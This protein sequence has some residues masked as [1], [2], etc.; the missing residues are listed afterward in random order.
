VPSLFHRKSSDPWCVA[1]IDLSSRRRYASTRT[2]DRPAAKRIGAKLEADAALRRNGVVNVRD[3][4]LAAQNRVP[5]REH[6]ADYVRPLELLGR[7]E[8]HVRATR[9]FLESLDECLGTTR[10]SVI[11]Q[12]AVEKYLHGLKA[13]GKSARTLNWRQS[14]VAGF[15]AW[16]VRAGRLDASPQ[17][18]LHR[19]LMR[20]ASRL[21]S[22]TPFH[23]PDVV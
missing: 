3:E 2:T 1:W 23:A 5:L 11:T 16:A 10:L 21:C 19:G 12:D 4:Q 22:V 7:T 20:E 17:R 18:A 8:K 14:L 15:L 13:K 9:C 6:V